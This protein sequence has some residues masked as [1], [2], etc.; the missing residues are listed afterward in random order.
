MNKLIQSKH[1]NAEENIITNIEIKIDNTTNTINTINSITAITQPVINANNNLPVTNETEEIYNVNNSD[2]K[3]NL[4]IPAFNKNK[5]CLVNDN[6]RVMFD[7]VE[8]IV[9]VF[10]KTFNDKSFDQLLDVLKASSFDF[11]STYLNLVDPGFFKSKIVNN[12][13]VRYCLY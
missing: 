13:N 3:I 1:R 7:A 4:S 12:K 6:D 10:S 5:V 2:K 9:N 11:E 8:D